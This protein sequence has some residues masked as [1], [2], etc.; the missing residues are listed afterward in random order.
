[1][2]TPQTYSIAL[3]LM[4]LSMLCWGSWA[5]TQKITRGWPFELYYFDYSLG[6]LA[7]AL[8]IG[9]TLGQ[10][11]PSS[12]DSF[13]LNLR[14][15]SPRSLLLAFA[16]GAVFSV[17][18]ILIVAA[19]S[20]AGM[21]VAFPIGAGLALVLGAVLNY[22][23]SPAGNPVLIFS[24]IGLVCI[25]IILDAL[26]YK[27]M[28]RGGAASGKGILLSF[29]GGIGA[30]LFYPLVAKSLTG[31]AHLQPYTVNVVFGLG[32][33][34]SALPMIYLLLRRPISGPPLVLKDYGK[35]T[36]KVHAWGIAGG[37]IWGVGTIANFVASYVPMIGPAT[38]FSMG[39]GNTMISALWGVF[40]WK[41]FRG[42]S[43]RVRLYLAL[44][45]LCFLLG[46]TSIAL[47]PV[48]K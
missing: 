33:A 27:G 32:A 20:V 10:I 40:V 41:E 1:M 25:A 18:N 17:G 48:I 37:L 2:F 26:A 38:S 7:C 31:P 46:L 42:A 5:N 34:A 30:G 8:I 6:L 23:V 24:G 35:G 45:F 11:N 19:I 29:V 22:V 3:L 47:S 28:S 4:T 13:F 21:A 14:A 36:W 9:L 15:A 12:P 16:G 39:E 43:S 44:M